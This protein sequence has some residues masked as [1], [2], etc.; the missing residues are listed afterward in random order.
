MS[1]WVLAWKG[2]APLALGKV[3][4]LDGERVDVCELRVD[5]GGDGLSHLERRVDEVLAVAVGGSKERYDLIVD[6]AK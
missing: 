1:S 5:G 3:E 6:W 2:L 4:R